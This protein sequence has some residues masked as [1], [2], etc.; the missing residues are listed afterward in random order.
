MTNLEDLSMKKQMKKAKTTKKL[1][2]KAVRT[3]VKA[4]EGYRVPGRALEM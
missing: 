1:N 4:G 3:G 2:L